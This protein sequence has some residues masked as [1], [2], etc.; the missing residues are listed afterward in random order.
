[1]LY[2]YDT[3]YLKLYTSFPH[4]FINTT[5]F[6]LTRANKEATRQNKGH[7]R[8]TFT[9]FDMYHFPV[10]FESMNSLV[11]EIMFAQWKLSIRVYWL[12]TFIGNWYCSHNLI[13][14]TLLTLLLLSN[15]Y[16]FSLGIESNSGFVIGEFH[17]SCS[18]SHFFNLFD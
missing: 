2:I 17:I 10:F 11:Y 16:S 15:R 13:S 8:K 12:K 5:N 3:S 1:M 4:D 7:V 9:I 14:N 18:G 6:C